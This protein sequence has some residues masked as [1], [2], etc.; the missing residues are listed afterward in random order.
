MR[1]SDIAIGL[2]VSESAL[3]RA[4]KAVSKNGDEKEV[5][6]IKLA[7]AFVEDTMIDVE[8]IARKI[9]AGLISGREQQQSILSLLHNVCGNF[10]PEGFIKRNREIA[11]AIYD[12]NQ[13]S[14]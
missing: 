5:L 13:Y 11:Q 12:E 14:C 8:A 7:T 1:L 2:Y 6:K 3:F 10:Q 4:V 9:I